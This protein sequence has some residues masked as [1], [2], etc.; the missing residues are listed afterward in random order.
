[1]NLVLDI[2]NTQFKMCVFDHNQIEFH[3]FY[4][5]LDKSLINHLLDEYAIDKIIYSDT[6]GIKHT[7]IAKLFPSEIKIIA[8]NHHT[9]LPI[10][11]NYDTP[12][13]L[14]KDR[15]AGAVGSYEYF[16][17]FPILIIDIGTALTIDFVSAS[18]VFEGGIISPGP[19]LRYKALHEFTGK[20]PLFAP[21]EDTNTMGSSTQ[22]A[23]ESGVQNGLLFE[24]NEYILTFQKQYSN[25]KVVLTGGYYYL[26]DKKIKYPIF[27][28]AFLIPKGLNRIL[29]YNE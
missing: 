10:K 29:N 28:D 9:P 6:R 3:S 2:G 23:I 1:M 13:T 14:G 22:S 20:L 27:A 16:P 18:G 8:L 26:F 15:I 25:L 7:D 5:N 12:E 24:I 4:N 11:I 21:V 17:G 19:E